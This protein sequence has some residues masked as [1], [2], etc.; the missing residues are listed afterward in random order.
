MNKAIGY[1]VQYRRSYNTAGYIAPWTLD[2]CVTNDVCVLLL[3]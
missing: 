3:V 2:P 1:I